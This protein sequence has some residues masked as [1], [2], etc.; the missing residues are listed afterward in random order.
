MKQVKQ[1]NNIYTKHFDDVRDI[2]KTAGSQFEN[3]TM[4]WQGQL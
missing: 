1:G 3:S 2:A 4:I